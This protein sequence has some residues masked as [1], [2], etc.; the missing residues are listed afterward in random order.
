MSIPFTQYLRPSGRRRAI[1]IERDSVVEALAYTFIDAGGKYEAEEL[2]SGMVSL[3]ACMV[4]DEEWQDVE[5]EICTNG[6]A[7]EGAVDELVARSVTHI[8][9]KM[10]TEDAEGK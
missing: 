9:P 3:T 4:V 5:I 10:E 2:M 7:I 1:E 8:K 6:P